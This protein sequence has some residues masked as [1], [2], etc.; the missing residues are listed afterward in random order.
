[1]SSPWRKAPL[2]RRTL[3]IVAIGYAVKT[4]IVAVAWVLVPE[5]PQIVKTKVQAAWTA[6]AGSSAD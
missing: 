3:K 2:N 6:V 1:V 4:L 5:L